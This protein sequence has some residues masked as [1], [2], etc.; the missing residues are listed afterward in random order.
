M[1]NHEFVEQT[2][3][4][5][6]SFFTFDGKEQGYYSWKDFVSIKTTPNGNANKTVTYNMERTEDAT[7]RNLYLNYPYSM[8]TSELFHDPVVGVNPENSPK[9][10]TKPPEKIIGHEL[11]IYII[12]AVI[13]GVIMLGSIYRQRKGRE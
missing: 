10:P 5:K 7:L 8:D 1:A 6:I 11:I 4:N 3:E 2:D 12:V 9:L 13:A